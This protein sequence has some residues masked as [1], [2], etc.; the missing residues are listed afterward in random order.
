MI[1]MLSVLVL[2]AGVPAVGAAQAV[3]LPDT[4]QGRLATAFF[5]AV[6]A[7]DG[8]AL[9]RFQE[10][11]FSEAALKR[12]PAQERKDRNRQLREQ[13]GTLT[14]VDVK[15]ASANQLVVTATGS[16]APGLMLTVTFVFTEG[17]NPKIDQLQISG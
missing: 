12:R 15:S 1:R 16:N 10:A 8:A 9:D 13:A 5:A 2:L 3:R 14:V 11:N 6:N 17:P 7:Q 4:P